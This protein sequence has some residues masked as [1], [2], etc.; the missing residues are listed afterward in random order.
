MKK[1][2]YLFC[3]FFIGMIVA[4][5]VVPGCSHRNMPETVEN[6]QAEENAGIDYV[7]AEGADIGKPMSGL[8]IFTPQDGTGKG[9]P[10][11]V[12][13]ATTLSFALPPLRRSAPR[14]TVMT[15]LVKQY[16]VIETSP[17]SLVFTNSEASLVLDSLLNDPNVQKQVNASVTIPAL[18]ITN[19]TYTC[20]ETATASSVFENILY[21]LVFMVGT[22]SNDAR[23]ATLDIGTEAYSDYNNGLM[24]TATGTGVFTNENKSIRLLEMAGQPYLSVTEC[25]A[26]SNTMVYL[27]SNAVFFVWE[28]A[29][30]SGEYRNYNESLPTDL[31]EDDLKM[32]DFTSWRIKITGI[33]DTSLISR[34]TIS[35]TVDSTSQITFSKVKGALLSDQKFILIPDGDL[36]AEPP[37]GYIPIRSDVETPSKENPKADKVFVEVI[38]LKQQQ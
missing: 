37:Q 10:I 18:G 12:P 28:T 31:S 27:L 19:A 7:H 32:G 13:P 36:E 25:Y 8:P 5:S 24:E 4:T 23:S 35:T 11:W 33:A 14:A 2:L 1:R 34:V 26:Y 16:T 3:I 15:Y 9:Q 21:G 6:P 29:P 38:P 22:S 17:N 20:L 30:Q